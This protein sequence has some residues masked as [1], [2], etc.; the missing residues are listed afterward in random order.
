MKRDGL[1]S[2]QKTNGNIQ[3]F[4]SKKKSN[5][6]R[7][8][9]NLARVEKG[10]EILDNTVPKKL[11]AAI[12]RELLLGPSVRI[13]G[14]NCKGKKNSQQKGFVTRFLNSR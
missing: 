13:R 2:V 14:P 3:Q 7:V 6:P 9:L 10:K 11:P 4:I 1:L 12:C 5:R 8:E